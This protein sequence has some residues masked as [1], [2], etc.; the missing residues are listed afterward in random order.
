[1]ANGTNTVAVALTG[2]G[3]PTLS[4]DTPMFQA[5]RLL[6]DHG[7]DVNATG[8]NGSTLLHQSVNRGPAF[9]R[10]LIEHG[11]KLDAKDSSGRTPLDVALG[12]PATV[13]AGAGGRGA[14]GGPAG[15]GAL[16]PAS[17][18]DPATLALL[19]GQGTAGSDSR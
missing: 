16:A 17:A 9:V 13:T 14:R 18:P 7:A 11:A 12:A 6:L 4:A 15:P 5:V 2:R 3:A 8:A 10:L 1:M 19:R